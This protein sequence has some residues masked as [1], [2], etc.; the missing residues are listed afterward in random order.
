MGSI[1]TCEGGWKVGRADLVYSGWVGF[2]GARLVCGLRIE[3]STPC[4]LCMLAGKTAGRRADFLPAN[5]VQVLW[6]GLWRRKQPLEGQMQPAGLDAGIWCARTL[7]CQGVRK[8]CGTT[9][10]CI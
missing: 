4:Y 7:F 5:H 10:M 3:T 6:V 8:W 2:W 1:E 9:G